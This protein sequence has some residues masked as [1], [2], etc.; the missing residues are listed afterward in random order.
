MSAYLSVRLV[1]FRHVSFVDC[2]GHDILMATMLNGAAVMDAALLLIGETPAV[3]CARPSV[4]T[5][6]RLGVGFTYFV[7]FSARVAY[8]AAVVILTMYAT[9]GL[10]YKA[11]FLVLLGT[12]MLE[13]VN[14][15]QNVEACLHFSAS[16]CSLTQVSLHHESNQLA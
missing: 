1:R 14:K 8:W 4:K 9:C 3:G 5:A 11:C 10:I 6:L 12:L 7:K 2:P 15:L 13:N 16:R